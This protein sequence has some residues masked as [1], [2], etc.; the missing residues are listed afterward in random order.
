MQN[1]QRVVRQIDRRAGEV[2]QARGSRSKQVPAKEEAGSDRADCKRCDK[3]GCPGYAI[4]PGER[5]RR[6]QQ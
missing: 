1:A 6:G 5:N 2:S 3:K 4:L